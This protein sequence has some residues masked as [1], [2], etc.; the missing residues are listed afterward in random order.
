MSRRDRLFV[1][2][3]LG[4][5]GLVAVP[6]AAFRPVAEERALLGTLVGWGLALLIM[7]PSYALL[8]RALAEENPH[9]F[10]SAFMVGSILRIF[11]TLIGVVV[12]WF[13]AQPAP[14]KSFLLAFLGGYVLLSAVELVLTRRP[15]AAA[16]RT[17]P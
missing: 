1:L 9:R 4:L 11:L 13:A 8:N 5:T 2:A 12:F 16:T 10:V 3:V 7:V 15:R 14:I 6:L 17:A